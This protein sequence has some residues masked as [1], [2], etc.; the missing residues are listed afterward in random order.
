MVQRP[1]PPPRALL[2]QIFLL[3]LLTRREKGLLPPATLSCR[4]A[5]ASRDC[6][7]CTLSCRRVLALVPSLVRHPRPF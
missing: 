3:L 7:F 5:Y 2:S 4:R 1:G 6:G